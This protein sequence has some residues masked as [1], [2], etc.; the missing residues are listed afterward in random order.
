MSAISVTARL[1]G[2]ASFLRDSR[3]LT[4]PPASASLLALLLVSDGPVDRHRLAEVVGPNGTEEVVRK[5]IN[6]AV[7]RLR[8]VLEPPGVAGHSVVATVS[9]GLALRCQAWVDVR[10]FESAC[11][12]LPDPR[13]WDLAVATVVT[14]GLQLYQ[15]EFLDGFESE[16]AL[17]ERGRLADTHLS[18]LV[19]LAQWHRLRGETHQVIDLARRAVDLEPMLEEVHGLLMRAYVDAGLPELAARQ[20]DRCRTI[21]HTELGVEPTPETVAAAKGRAPS[22]NESDVGLALRALERSHAE[23]RELARQLSR[24]LQQLDQQQQ[25]LRARL[26]QS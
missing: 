21:L 17:A 22:V 26:D 12:H 11:A 7:W 8:R 24:S 4:L 18:A 5:R 13:Q 23:L 16:W 1:L 2:P 9:S 19:R 20:L 15:G 14:R 3:V 25:S 10:E 6:T